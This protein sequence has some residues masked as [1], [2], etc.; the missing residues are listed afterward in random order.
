MV[1]LDNPC[2]VRRVNVKGIEMGAN[3]LHGREVLGERCA[4]LEDG[5]FGASRVA[6][7][8]AM[9]AFVLCADRGVHLEFDVKCE[10]FRFSLL[11][12]RWKGKFTEKMLKVFK[13]VVKPIYIFRSSNIRS[14]DDQRYVNDVTATGPLHKSFF[15]WSHLPVH[16]RG[17]AKIPNANKQYHPAMRRH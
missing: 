4:R 13:S 11:L 6:R 3:I 1:G 8:F 17:I 14:W 5:T 9:G 12:K 7:H 16:S 10:G 2:R 15:A